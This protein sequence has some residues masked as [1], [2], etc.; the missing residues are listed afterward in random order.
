MFI[1]TSE[2]GL[3]GSVAHGPVEVAGEQSVAVVG[4]GAGKQV[5]DDGADWL[6]HAG[7]LN[8]EVLAAG[9]RVGHVWCGCGVDG[10]LASHA[11]NIYETPPPDQPL[12]IS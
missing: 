3:I 11:S 10:R 5:A 1:S 7:Q 6:G 8:V 2:C 9:V 12:H 4:Q